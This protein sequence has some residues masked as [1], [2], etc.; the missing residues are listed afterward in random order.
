MTMIRNKMDQ[1][2]QKVINQM[3]EKTPECPL[4]MQKKLRITFEE[5]TEICKKFIKFVEIK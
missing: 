2:K 1:K 4:F 3:R 5:A